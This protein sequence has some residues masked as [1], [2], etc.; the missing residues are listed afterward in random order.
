MRYFSGISDINS[1]TLIYRRLAMLNHPD[2]GGNPEVMKRIN[3]EYEELKS[4]LKGENKEN[5]GYSINQ[6]VF[7]N[8]SPARIIHIGEYIIIVQST[9]TNRKAIFNKK[10][11]ICLSN[12]ELKLSTKKHIRYAGR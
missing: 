2:M 11:G 8:K 4:Q 5:S 9:L 3:I 7:V 10:S 1:L 12:P 6:E